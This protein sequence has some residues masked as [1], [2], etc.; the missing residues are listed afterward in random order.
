LISRARELSEQISAKLIV[1]SNNEDCFLES[2][3]QIFQR[4]V[5]YGGSKR[6]RSLGDADGSAEPYNRKPAVRNHAAYR[7]LRHLPVF[8]HL[9]NS[10]EYFVGRMVSARIT[11]VSA[12][13]AHLGVS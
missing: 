5:D 7:A 13:S 1:V 3:A 10:K 2:A 12:S 6:G 4:V 11:L 8:G 9:L